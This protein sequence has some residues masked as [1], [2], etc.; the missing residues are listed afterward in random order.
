M[1]GRIPQPRDCDRS[2]NQEPDAQGA[3]PPRCPKR[4]I[5]NTIKGEERGGGID[6]EWLGENLSRQWLSQ[7][8]C[9][10]HVCWNKFNVISPQFLILFS[11]CPRC[12]AGL[13]LP[14]T[15]PHPGVIQSAPLPAG[16][17]PTHRYQLP[18]FLGILSHSICSL[19]PSLVRFYTYLL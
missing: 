14:P 4:L 19:P 2:C 12:C 16:V 15:C 10:M 9:N 5:L 7:S 11:I 6:S 1:W 17:P 8:A 13:C 3:E 18:C